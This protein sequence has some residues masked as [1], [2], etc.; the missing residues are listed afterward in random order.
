VNWRL[1]ATLAGAGPLMGALTVLG[2]FPR[3]ADRF[4]W[5][6]V[7]V[8]CALV[9]AWRERERALLHGA[10]LGFWNGASSTLVQALFV[11]ELVANNPWF[12]SSFAHQPRGFNLEYFVFM[13]VPFIGV[14]GGALTGLVAM[15]AA[16]ALAARARRR[17][18]GETC[19]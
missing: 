10:V 19:P 9:T 2:V 1:L 13:L 12:A 3:G 17:G 7:V 16:R 5:S 14:A 8:V 4:V 11:E 18:D 15:L 6:G